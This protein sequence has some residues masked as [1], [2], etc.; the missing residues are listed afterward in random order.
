MNQRVLQVRPGTGV[1]EASHV[2]SE[3]V[4][5]MA[6]GLVDSE[7]WYFVTGLITE[8]PRPRYRRQGGDNSVKKG[9]VECYSRPGG[10]H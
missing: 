2:G 1:R 4:D 3:R 10:G 9:K 7:L 6:E 5:V 8:S